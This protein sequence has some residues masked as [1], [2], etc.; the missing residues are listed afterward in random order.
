[1]KQQFVSARGRGR[2]TYD[3]VVV[4]AGLV[5]ASI[6]Y[7]LGKHLARVALLDEGDVA[8]RAS[9]GNFGLV[10]VQSKGAGMAPYGAWTLGAARLWP[11]LAASLFDETGVDVHLKQRGGLHVML[12]EEELRA[13]VSFMNGLKAQPGMP[14]SGWRLLDRREVADVMPGL[15]P[16]VAGAIWTDVDGA[17]NPLELLRALHTTFFSGPVHYLPE[18]P[19]RSI[20]WVNGV[21]H[22]ATPLGRIDTRKLVIAAGLG[23]TALAAQV[24]LDMPVRPQRGQVIVLERSRRRLEVPLSTLRQMD[25]GSWLIGDSQQEAGFDDQSVGFDVLATLADRA[26]RTLPALAQLSVVRAWSALRVMPRDGFP[27]YDQ[28]KSCPGAFVAACHSGVTLAA[29]HALKL[30]PMIA[31]GALDRELAPFST[32]RFHVQAS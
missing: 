21:F 5:G 17:V 2:G 15:G 20:E 27:I 3:A 19:A 25:E 10:W 4:G 31:A 29:A 18:T 24:G 11:R 13:R 1:M 7:G 28:S 16:D 12:S 32:R 14:D 26:R 8:Y 6:A 23:S 30:A 22:I 9:R